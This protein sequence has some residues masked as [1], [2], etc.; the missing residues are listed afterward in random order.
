MIFIDNSYR[1]LLYL[2]KAKQTNAHTQTS[3]GFMENSLIEL[4]GLFLPSTYQHCFVSLRS[5]AMSLRQATTIQ[6]SET[7]KSVYN[8]QFLASVRLWTKV[9]CTFNQT[10][11]PKMTLKPLIYPLVQIILGAM[12]LKP[13]AKHL[14]LRL[15]FINL[16]TLLSESTLVYI[17]IASYILEILDSA[18]LRQTPKPSTLKPLDFQL[19]VRAPT[20]YLGTKTFQMGVLEEVVAVMWRFVTQEAGGI[21]FPE[22]TLP[23]VVAFKRIVKRGDV[24]VSRQISAVLEKVFFGVDWVGAR[25]SKV[26]GRETEWSRVRAERCRDG[27]RFRD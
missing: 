5:L 27:G 10:E 2:K 15:M 3:I 22:I 20:G 8:W 1:Y 19:N 25:E 6:G 23:L 12:R 14:P 17:P 24:G 18:E 7:Y 21:G 4:Y 13:S 9:I 11:D 16:L 26:C